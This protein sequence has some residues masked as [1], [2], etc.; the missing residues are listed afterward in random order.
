MKKIYPNAIAAA[1][2]IKP[3]IPLIGN[4]GISIRD[5]IELELL[6]E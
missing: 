6:L 1:R 4:Y 2:K 3:E 5:A